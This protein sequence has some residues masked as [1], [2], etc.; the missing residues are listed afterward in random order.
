LLPL[1]L[2]EGFRDNQGSREPQLSNLSRLLGHEELLLI[3]HGREHQEQEVGVKWV[4][5]RFSSGKINKMKPNKKRSEKTKNKMKNRVCLLMFISVRKH[6][7]KR[8][9]ASPGD[10][11]VEG[12]R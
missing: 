4:H 7:G 5:F 8:L 2:L 1:L 6:S 9:A 10:M 12:G 11:E 3:I